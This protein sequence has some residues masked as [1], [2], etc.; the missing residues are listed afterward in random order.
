MAA[1]PIPLPHD[2]HEKQLHVLHVVFS[3]PLPTPINY[4][5]STEIYYPPHR[6]ISSP[7]LPKIPSRAG[8]MAELWCTSSLNYS[9]I[10]I[11]SPAVSVTSAVYDAIYLTAT[12][13]LVVC[14]LWKCRPA[15]T[16]LEQIASEA[17]SSLSS[18][19]ENSSRSS[20]GS[21]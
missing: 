6:Q 16:F 3:T 7:S 15:L 14:W 19:F 11:R 10:S 12:K 4:T 13:G 20:I 18:R 1:L 17:A 5:C 2:S 8:V 21:C 9:R